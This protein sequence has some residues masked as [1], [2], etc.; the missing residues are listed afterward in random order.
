MAY[1]AVKGGKE[2]IEESIERLKLERLKGGHVLDVEDIQSGERLLVDQ[3]MSESFLYSPQLAS[4]AIKQGEGSLEE[5]VFLMRAYR[6][7]L[8]RNI[9][10]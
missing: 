7:T 2:A 6:S 10:H 8:P 3:V 4:L 9:I 5:A 1:V